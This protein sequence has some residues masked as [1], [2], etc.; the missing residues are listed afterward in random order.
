MCALL[1]KGQI[2]ENL[3]DNALRVVRQNA[4]SQVAG[5]G[6]FFVQQGER[7]L[8]FYV[9]TRGYA[10]I[11]QVTQ[12]GHQVLIRY[13]GPG[14]EF[15]LVAVLSGFEYPA[16]VQAV[17][18][19]EALV[20]EGELLAQ[21]IERYPRIG[22]NALRILAQQNQELQRRYH[23]LLTQRV[24]QRLAQSILRLAHQAGR[25]T[26]EGTLIDLSLSREDLA[27]MVGTNIYTVSRIMSR[28]EQGGLVQSDRQ[29][30]RLLCQ[31]ALEQVAS[32]A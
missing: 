25:S 31:A 13:I 17:E 1:A 8:R 18:E 21:L 24:E 15:G 9:L 27:E 22:F 3:E 23:E 11:V 32:A 16:S 19:C 6:E 20:W 12:D 14:Q 26:A 10:K 28:W 30:V 5:S 7:A 4:H 2:F 29:S